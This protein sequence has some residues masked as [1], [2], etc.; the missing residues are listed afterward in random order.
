MILEKVSGMSYG[1]FLSKQ[2]FIPLGM[3]NTFVLEKNTGKNRIICRGYTMFYG[4]YDNDL[5]TT[6]DGGIY[7]SADDMFKWDQ[8]LYS[9]KLVNKS[10]LDEAFKPAKLNDGTES[11]YGFGWGIIKQSG[12]NFVLHAGELNGFN[13]FILRQLTDEYTVIFLT[14]IAGTQRKPIYDGIYNILTGRPYVYPKLYAAK[15][16]YQMI[17]E[18]GWNNA[19]SVY[20]SLKKNNDSNYIFSEREMNI[21]G[22]QLMTDSKLNAAINVF[23]QNTEDYP[24]SSNVYE[25]L[26]EAYMKNGENEKAISS[27]QK[28]LEI[29]P[30]NR[31]A[32]KLMNELTNK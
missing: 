16:M 7:S 9:D 30:G 21:L 1:D 3:N 29:D 20:D 6:G 26:G 14:N 17:N 5:L 27:F 32:K 23:K 4:D 19:F 13:T 25:S 11:N 18:G 22:Y 15:I 31:D 8:A 2:I 12:K 28:S 10:N 24:N